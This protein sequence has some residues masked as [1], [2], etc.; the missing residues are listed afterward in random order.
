MSN[1]LGKKKRLKSKKDIDYLFAE[2]R[3]KSLPPLRV[4][5]LSSEDIINTKA[6]FSVPKKR[7]GKA[8]DRNKIKRLLREAYRLQQKNLNLNVHLA[9]VYVGK[10]IPRL[11]KIMPAV[12]EALDWI[13]STKEKS[14]P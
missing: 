7:F 2:A 9:L 5:V 13:N 6:L 8:V 14:T 12:K 3:F 11:E 10:E 4:L 1:T